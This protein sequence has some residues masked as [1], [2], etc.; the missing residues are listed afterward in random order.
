MDWTAF[1]IAALGIL[2]TLLAP[3]IAHRLEKTRQSLANARED[4]AILRRKLEE[5]LGEI[6]RLQHLAN[7]SGIAAMRI[8]N[9]EKGVEQQSPFDL[10]RL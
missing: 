4:E 3:L 6:D 2:R 8:A 7:L 5:T 9:G 10:G 1:G